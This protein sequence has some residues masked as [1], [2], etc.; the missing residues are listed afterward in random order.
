LF[1]SHCKVSL[2]TPLIRLLI[3]SNFCSNY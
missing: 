3:S 2:G 1:P